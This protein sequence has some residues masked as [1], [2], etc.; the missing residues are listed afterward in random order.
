MKTKI[1]NERDRRGVNPNRYRN[2]DRDRGGAVA[3]VEPLSDQ[4][5]GKKTIDCDTD[6]DFDF[7]DK[8]QN[9]QTNPRGVIE[10]GIG[11]GI[12]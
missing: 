5:A 7:D 4:L 9:Q 3:G 2:R 11:I 8:A 1:P 6:S 12:K 10:I